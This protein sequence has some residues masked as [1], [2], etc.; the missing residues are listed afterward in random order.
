MKVFRLIFVGLLTLVVASC[1][2]DESTYPT[3]YKATAMVTVL[4]NSPSGLLLEEYMSPSSMRMLSATHVE[5][6][7]FSVGRRLLVSYN[8]NLADTML[9]PVPVRLTGYRVI[10]FD[11]IRTMPLEQIV[12]SPKG[13]VKVR[14]QWISGNFLNFQCRLLFDGSTRDYTLVADESTLANPEI[15]CYFVATRSAV[16][17]SSVYRRDFASFYFGTLPVSPSQKFVVREIPKF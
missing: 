7:Y 13:G 6:K 10:Q 11:T 16:A 8:A 17:D 5:S 4:S 9:N 12:A 1:S 2:D 15:D 14:S 3:P